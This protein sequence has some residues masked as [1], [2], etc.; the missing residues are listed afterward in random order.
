MAWGEGL[1]SD[2]AGI[3]TIGGSDSRGP[4]SR[5]RGR[6]GIASGTRNGN[7]RVAIGGRDKNGRPKSKVETMRRQLVY[8]GYWVEIMASGMARR[9]MNQS[10]WNPR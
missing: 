7:D 9:L 2:A 8:R 10:S 1:G 3:D 4:G 6:G 5:G